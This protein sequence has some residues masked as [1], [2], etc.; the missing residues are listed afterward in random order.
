MGAPAGCLRGG[1]IEKN[2]GLETLRKGLGGVDKV[3]AEQEKETKKLFD[4]HESLV[5]YQFQDSSEMSS[6][7]SSAV[8]TKLVVLNTGS[9]AHGSL[10]PR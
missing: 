9:H 7:N 8:S 6:E 1:K 4:A 10:R 5:R 2:R 3:V